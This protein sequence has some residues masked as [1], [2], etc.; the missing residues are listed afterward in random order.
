[1]K[2]GKNNMKKKINNITTEELNKIDIHSHESYITEYYKEFYYNEA[3]EEHY[4]LLMYLS[5]LFL[6]EEDVIYFDI[7]THQGMSAIA[8]AENKNAKVISYDIT[9]NKTSKL[10]PSNI[11]FK[12]GNVIEDPNLLKAKFIFI[13]TI[14]DGKFEKE[15][16]DFLRKNHYIGIIGLD[17]IYLNENMRNLWNLELKNENKIDV[18]HLGH[19]S[20]TGLIIF[21]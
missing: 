4:R 13:D 1:M 7:G 3:G 15:V 18:S 2:N 12:I 11:E 8:L 16:I 9:D 10:F 6:D 21:E 5:N 17:D 14:H 20:G 19:W